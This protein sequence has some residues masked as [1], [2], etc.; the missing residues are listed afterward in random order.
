MQDGD[1]VLIVTEKRKRYLV[2]LRAG[3]RFHCSEGFIELDMLVG[4]SYGCMVVSNTGSRWRVFRPT[5]V[6][7]VMFYPRTTQIVYP[8]DLGYIVVATGIGPG[9]G[10][11]RLGQGQV[12]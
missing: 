6:D 2:Q 12:S 3:K 7:R 4:K 11:W 8:K 5:I 1:R 10:C 9:C